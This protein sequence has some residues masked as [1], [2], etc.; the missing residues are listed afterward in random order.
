MTKKEETII[1]IT[2]LI[3]EWFEKHGEKVVKPMDDVKYDILQ[4]TEGFEGLDL[5]PDG[6]E[7]DYL[8]D[9]RFFV[10][11]KIA[12]KWCGWTLTDSD[13]WQVYKRNK[14]N[15]YS[16]VQLSYVDSEE[17]ECVVFYN[18]NV[19]IPEKEELEEILHTHGAT[20]E[21]LRESY[22]P[23]IMWDVCAGYVFEECCRDFD[24]ALTG[25]LSLERAIEKICEIITDP[26]N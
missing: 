15:G 5:D 19:K 13:I 24:K 3:A 2:L 8:T 11:A 20:L 21:T 17:K 6:Y 9:L 22:G 1:E 10:L 23:D 14:D 4:W 7:Y 25:R 18:N 16:M 26:E 12:E